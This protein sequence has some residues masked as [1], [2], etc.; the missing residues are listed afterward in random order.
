MFKSTIKLLLCAFLC[1]WSFMTYAQQRRVTGTITDSKSAPV[2]NASVML[3]GTNVGTTTDAGGNFSISVNGSNAV[4]EISSV[5]F[6]SKEVNVGQSSHLTITLEGGAGT[7]QEVVVTALGIQKAKKSLGYSMQEVS[8]QAIVESREVNL[9]ND[10]S[11]KVSGLQIVRSGNGPSG[12]S[13]ILLRG[14]NS[15]TGT[16]QPLIVVDGIPMDNAIG[17]VGIGATNDFWNPSL[18]MGN[19]LSDINPDDIASISVLKGPAAAA[20]YG[21]LGGNGV[22]IITTK[23]GK[24]QPGLGV[25]VSSS[26]GFEG[27]LTNPE[28]QNSF[29]QGS[30]NVYD[31]ISGSSWG[32]KIAGQSVVDWSGKQV[33]LEPH[34]NVSNFFNNGIVSNQNISFQQRVNSTGIYVSYNRFDDKSIIPGAKLMRNNITARTTTK[35]GRNEHWSIDTKVQY[36]NATAKNRSLEG[37]NGSIF[38]TIYNLP[39][40]LNILNFK[41]P[42]DQNGNMFWWQK[43]SGTNPYWAAQYN[44]NSDVRD[45]YILYAAVGHDFNSWL[46]ADINGGVDMYTTN[47]ENK[48]FAGSPASTGGQ[49]GLGKQTYHQTNFSGRLTAKKDDLFGKLGGSVMVGGNLMEW[50]NSAI[51]ISAGNLRVPNL[52]TV[53]NSIGNPGVSQ[54]FARKKI[55]SV[56]GSVELN[57]DGYLYLTGTF[58]NDWSS[59]LAPKNNS[60]FYPSVSLSYVF[61]DM[62]NN[63]GGTLPSWLSFGKLRASYAEAGS[64]L[65]PYELFNTYRI[66]TD[67]NG[68]TTASRRGTL[69]DSTVRSQLIRSYE[70]G[71]ELRFFDNRVSLDVSVYK[72]NAIRQLINLPMD[73]LS[74]YSSMKI[75][76][77]NVQNKGIEVTANARIIQSKSSF[78]WDMGVNFSH[79]KNTVPYIYQGVNKYQLGGFDNIQVLA[80]AGEPYGEIYGNKLLRVTDNKDPNYGQLILSTNGL[81]QA[82]TD[83][84]RLG[85]QQ[86]TALLGLSNSFTYKGFGLSIL[87]DARIGG[88]IFSQTLD[89]MERSGTALITAGNNRD[90]MIVKGV[91][92]VSGGGYTSNTTKISAQQYWT[93]LAGPG[94]TGITEIN[95][96]DATNFRIRNIQLSY[97]FP[98][99]MLEN[100]FI[101]KA[102]VSVSCNNAWLIS[103]HMHGLD[104]ESAYASGT[105]AVGF[106][107]GS[108][109]TT[110]IFYF[111]FSLGF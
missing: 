28:M 46:K 21:S 109:P 44:L 20:L 99:K 18:D 15:L 2:S 17:R 57:Y 6:K 75:N 101:Q 48:M 73:P 51:N 14:N 103:S 70:A 106:E 72:S 105:P 85:N 98:R 38:A 16:S 13:Q 88:K 91:V 69:F 27:I 63:H 52:F 54:L 33:A 61:T 68:N 64:D 56:Y 67:P 30:N 39:R 42:L 104:P 76:A 95:L 71:A 7:L 78:N 79:N 53:T 35:F 47:T 29:A 60:F 22:I 9:V 90:S 96:Y 86:A 81:P 45:R 80:V 40:T 36:I 92:P 10:L 83:I 58:R 97:S 31:S 5:G 84:S 11:A 62:I 25:T 4:L 3:K 23:T 87:L 111:N 93:A 12:S 24:K 66:D 74:G 49:Y 110:R 108:A 59:A 19:G 50:Q 102:V 77:G 8:G 65:N 34:D 37:Q 82:T 100:S 43:G 55:N 107:N 32:P 1:V 94:N 26:V 41:D 89:N